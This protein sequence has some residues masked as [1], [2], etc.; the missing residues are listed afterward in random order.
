MLWLGGNS[1][2]KLKK[3]INWHSVN[4]KKIEQKVQMKEE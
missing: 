2:E 3:L 1:N 4:G